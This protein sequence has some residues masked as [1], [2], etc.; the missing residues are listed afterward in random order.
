MLR[1]MLVAL[2]GSSYCQ[3]ATDLAIRWALALRSNLT[4]L[5]VIDEPEI[6]AP[7][8]VPIGGGAFKWELEETRLKQARLTIEAAVERFRQCC[9]QRGVACQGLV[10]VGL[11]VEQITREAQRADLVLVGQETHFLLDGEPG[12][13]VHALLKAPPRPVVVVP[14]NPPEHKT[15]LVA[16]DGSLQASRAL[17]AFCQLGL[18]E[19]FDQFHV[20]TLDDNEEHGK[21]VSRYAVDLLK[22]HGLDATPQVLSLGRSADQ[23]ILQVAQERQ[24]GLL[25]MGCYG[26]PSLVEWFLGTTTLHVIQN[27]SVPLFLYQ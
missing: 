23:M 22:Q 18:P 15:V 5:G 26:R 16:Y 7:E 14:A 20:L 11:P 27:T 24:A 25:V 10:D 2:D 3:Q 4:G 17:W 9:Q 19:L 13:T 12:R 8:P 1:N 21:L 6:R